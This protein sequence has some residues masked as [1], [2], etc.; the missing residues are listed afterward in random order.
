MNDQL[1]DWLAGLAPRERNLVYA[2]GGLAIIALLYFVLVLPITTMAAKRA[3]RVE[4]KTADLAWM[5]QVAPQ[6]AAT[7]AAG[8]A[9]GSGESLVVL[10]DRTG[11]EA[12]LGGALRDQSPSGDQGLRL[13]LEA[14]SFDVL[15]VWLASLQQQHGVKVEAATIDATATS[16]L[17]NAS[18][19]LT[20]GATAGP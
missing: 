5:R 11:R 17:V 3:A 1:R 6:V 16:G 4:Q 13:R 12:G 2:A 9:A 10:V 20:H 8:A 18:L 15:V 19:T 7:A 14:A